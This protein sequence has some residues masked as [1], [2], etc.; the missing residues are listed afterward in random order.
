MCF[1]CI[2]HVSLLAT[3]FYRSQIG[4]LLL[5][6]LYGSKSITCIYWGHCSFLWIQ[7]CLIGLSGSLKLE[8]F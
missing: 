1:E 6:V 5:V 3:V 2:S 8:L 7:L 4:E